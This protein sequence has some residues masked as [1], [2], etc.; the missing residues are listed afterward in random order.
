QDPAAAER[1][2]ATIAEMGRGA[3]ADIR[4]ILGV[5]RDESATTPA[6]VPQPVDDDLDRLV[7]S[8]RDVGLGISIVRV[9][10]A[11]PL[12]AGAGLMLYRIAQEA[13]TNVLKHAGPAATVIVHLR[14]TA[15]RVILMVDDDGRGAAA[16]TDGKGQGLVGMRERAGVLGGTVQAG[17]R[18]GGGFR[19]RVDLPV[20]GAAGGQPAPAGS[21]APNGTA[22]PEGA[23]DPA[24]PAA[25]GETPAQAGAPAPNGTAAPGEPSP[26][27]VDP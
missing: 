17:P 9:G 7:Q 24:G 18:R 15:D 25:S 12:P 20:G 22:A 3:L 26:D 11:R 5:L 21:T 10:E 2:L 1:A 8:M 23:T 19:V 27:K 6:L 16:T 14:W 4:R 13:L